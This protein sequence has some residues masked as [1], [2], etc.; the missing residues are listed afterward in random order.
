MLKTKTPAI[1]K[2]TS[3]RSSRAGSVV[4]TTRV[5]TPHIPSPQES[6][7]PLIRGLKAQIAR[8]VDYM[9][10]ASLTRED[11]L[12]FISQLHTLNVLRDKLEIMRAGT[13]KAEL[14]QISRHLGKKMQSSVSD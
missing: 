9:D 6:L 10:G 2:H 13:S 5:A 4:R 7:T 14:A 1:R 8:L 3:A 11:E 12:F